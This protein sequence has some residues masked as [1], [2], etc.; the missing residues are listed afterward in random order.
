MD[1]TDTRGCYRAVKSDRRFGGACAARTHPHGRN[2]ILRTASISVFPPVR[3]VNVA[4]DVDGVEVVSHDHLDCFV[5][6]GLMSTVP[7]VRDWDMAARGGQ[8]HARF[9]WGDGWCRRTAGG[10][11]SGKAAARSSA[12]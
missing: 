10:A 1:T 8:R 9:A 12:S 4:G 7:V 11:I 3:H 6:L 5:H 2:Q